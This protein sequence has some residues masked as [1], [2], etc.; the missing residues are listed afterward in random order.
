M[1]GEELSA[2]VSSF[3][4]LLDCQRHC[5]VRTERG[6]IQR[7][8][9]SK[10]FLAVVLALVTGT[11]LYIKMPWPIAGTLVSSSWNEYF[12]RLVAL[13]DPWTYPGP[14]ASY[15]IMLFTTP[16]ICFS[17]FLAGLYIFSLRPR[18]ST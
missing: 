5:T 1:A 15:G 12:L 2:P 8:L 3:G 16:Y 4:S 10:N 6:M 9:N 11:V 7:V 18:P 14:K 13:Q 17:F